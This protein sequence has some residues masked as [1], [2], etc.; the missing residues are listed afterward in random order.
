MVIVE[1]SRGGLEL[2]K[3]VEEQKTIR[4]KRCG[5]SVEEGFTQGYAGRFLPAGGQ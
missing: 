3:I 5:A 2:G 4:K 1:T